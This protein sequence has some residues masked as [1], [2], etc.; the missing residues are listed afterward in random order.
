MKRK[1]LKKQ[2]FDGSSDDLKNEI[3]TFKEN[4]LKNTVFDV[5]FYEHSFVT[6]DNVDNSKKQELIINYIKDMINKNI[7]RKQKEESN[8]VEKVNEMVITPPKPAESKVSEKEVEE[9]KIKESNVKEEAKVEE[10][11]KPEEIEIKNT[12]KERI[13]RRR[14]KLAKELAS[15]K[16]K[17]NVKASVVNNV[18]EER[19]EEEIKTHNSSEKPPPPTI[20]NIK[21][22]NFSLTLYFTSP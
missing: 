9:S 1:S 2:K 17:N 4:F 22:L 18:V 8:K 3:N 13:R 16:A 10:I 14:P 19:K 5:Q 15:L 6:F 20:E 7:E 11:K 12:L 21:K